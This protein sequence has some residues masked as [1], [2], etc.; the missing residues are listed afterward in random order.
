MKKLVALLAASLALSGICLAQETPENL[1]DQAYNKIKSAGD[2]V[3]S[4]Q[5]LLAPGQSRDNLA[6]ALQLYVQ[7]G[8][9]FEQAGNM[10]KAV[11]TN[12]ASQSDIDNCEQATRNCIEAI[13]NIKRVLGSREVP[14][15]A[16]KVKTLVAPH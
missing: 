4:A 6:A 10:L 11:G 2:L 13:N 5:K 7:A 16:G 1:R 15:S 14:S 12:Y 8:Q 9:L 3:G